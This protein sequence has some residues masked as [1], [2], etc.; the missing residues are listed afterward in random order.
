ME[1][2]RVIDPGLLDDD[3]RE[4][5][6]WLYPDGFWAGA[7]H[8]LSR[9]LRPT[10]ARTEPEKRWKDTTGVQARAFT[11]ATCRAMRNLHA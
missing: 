7:P 6:D 10:V 11:G 9:T 4:V 8:T 3:A 1:V 2:L 5:W